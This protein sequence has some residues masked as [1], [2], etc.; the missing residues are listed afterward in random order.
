MRKRLFTGLQPSGDSLHIG[1]YLSAVKGVMALQHAHRL[2]PV[3]RGLSRH[4]GAL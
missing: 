3:H 2:H 1:N 4:Y